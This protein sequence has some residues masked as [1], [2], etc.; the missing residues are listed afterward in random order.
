[1]YARRGAGQAAYDKDWRGVDF[2]GIWCIM[3]TQR[4]AVSTS[5]SMCAEGARYYGIIHSRIQPLRVCGAAPLKS[6]LQI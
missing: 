3:L 5:D 2:A 4:C 6:A 1:M